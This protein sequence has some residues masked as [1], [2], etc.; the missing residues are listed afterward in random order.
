MSLIGF[1]NIGAMHLAGSA[2]GTQAGGADTDAVKQNGSAQKSTADRDAQ[3]ARA[4]GDVGE[5]DL[6]DD[7][8]ADG[9]QPWGRLSRPAVDGEGE[10]GSRAE[11]RTPDAIGER[12]AALDLRA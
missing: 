8:D 7:R 12:G 1:S 6:T 2:A 10:E 11:T 3:S 9:R 4:L 5:A